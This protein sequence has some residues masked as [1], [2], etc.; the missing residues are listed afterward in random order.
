MRQGNDSGTQY[1][2]GIYYYNDKQKE[3]AEQSKILYEKVCRDF[4]NL[5]PQTTKHRK[6]PLIIIKIKIS[7]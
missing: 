2:S 7:I 6:K 3:E 4:L 5:T 1:R